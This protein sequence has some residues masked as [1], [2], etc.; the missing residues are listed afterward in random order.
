MPHSC[1]LLLFS[2]TFLLRQLLLVLRK[3]NV[4]A[5]ITLCRTRFEL[6]YDILGMATASK[7][8]LVMAA[9]RLADLT[10]IHDLRQVIVCLPATGVHD[11]E[12]LDN[13]GSK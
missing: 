3:L 5:A 7:H 13:D 2:L 4:G 8:L 6:L 11:V 9:P 1:Q 12:A 10:L